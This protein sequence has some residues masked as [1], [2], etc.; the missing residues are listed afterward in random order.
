MAIA[1]L[2]Y[3][4]PGTWPFWQGELWALPHIPEASRLSP[5]TFHA[6]IEAVSPNPFAWMTTYPA[7][8]SQ[9]QAWTRPFS[10]HLV[11]EWDEGPIFECVGTVTFSAS[12]LRPPGEPYPTVVAVGDYSWPH[13]VVSLTVEYLDLDPDPVGAIRVTKTVE[14]AELLDLIGVSFP[15]DI[16]GAGDVETVTPT[17][18]YPGTIEPVTVALDAG[19]ELTF[20]EDT[21]DLPTT[22][23]GRP[24]RWLEPIIDPPELTVVSE[25]TLDVSVINRVTFPGGS[26]PLRQRQSLIGA[27]SW[28]VRQRQ[29]GGH[30]GSWPLRQRQDGT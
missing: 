10:L 29:N 2:T 14:G 30:P 19:L 22:I 20:S 11:D 28:P 15:I 25:T 5:I 8:P 6:A 24:A 1:P 9:S 16:E 13:S 4:G 23:G 17:V 7:S 21:Q 27:G 18:L 3:I 26:W 12:E